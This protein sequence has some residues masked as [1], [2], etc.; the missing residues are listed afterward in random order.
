[1][2]LKWFLVFQ[3]KSLI[4]YVFIWFF[5]SVMLHAHKESSIIESTST[6]SFCNCNASVEK[7]LYLL[8]RNVCLR[9][10]PIF[11]PGCL[12]FWYWATQAVCMANKHIKRCLTLL[13][14]AAKSL[15]SCPTLCNPIDG[16]P[17]GSAVPGIFQARVLKW[18][19]IAF[20]NAWK[21]KVKVKSLVMSN[22]SRHHGLQPTRLLRPWDFPGKSTEV[23]C[24]CLLWAHY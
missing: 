8:W 19:A 12:L 23:G 2:H 11:W 3:A 14:I 1:M 20:S 18:V 17:P 21:W 4:G 22:S 24:H 13:I 9:L 10:L 16:S 5:I 15:Q 6:L 7:C